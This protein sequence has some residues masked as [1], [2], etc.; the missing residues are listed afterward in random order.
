M[1]QME[2]YVHNFYFPDTH[3]LFL[4]PLTRKQVL[5]FLMTISS[6]PKLLGIHKYDQVSDMS[7]K[8]FI[9]LFHPLNMPWWGRLVAFSFPTSPSTS[10]FEEYKYQVRKITSLRAKSLNLHYFSNEIEANHLQ[11]ILNVGMNVALNN[12]V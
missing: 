9:K 3:D 11:R 8:V 7:W 10:S 12:D 5:D 6:V 2:I 4:I 1:Y